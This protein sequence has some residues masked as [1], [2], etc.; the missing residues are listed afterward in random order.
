[1]RLFSFKTTILL[2]IF[3]L[4]PHVVHASKIFTV[5]AGAFSSKTNAQNLITVL[6]SHGIR[7]TAYE[8][9]GLSKVQ[10]GE[11]STQ[12]KADILRK[13]LS[14][15]GFDVFV[16]PKVMRNPQGTRKA[17]IEAEQSTEA[18]VSRQPETDQ[19]L[20]PVTSMP[21][22]VPPVEDKSEPKAQEQKEEVISAPQAPVLLNR[23]VAVVNK[24]VITWSELYRAMEFEAGTQIENLSAEERKKLLK[25]SEASFLESLIDARL[26]LQE[27][28]KLGIE[29]TPREVT[30][31]VETVK[32]KYSMTQAD[33]METLKKEGLTF[34]GYKKRLSEEIMINKVVA[35]EIR[36]KIVVSDDE[37]TKYIE[38][39]RVNFNGNV[40]Y[41]LRQLFLRKPVDGDKKTV[42]EKATLIIKRLRDGEDFSALARIYSDDPSRKIGGDLGSVSRDLLAKEFVE[43]LS[44]MKVGDYSMPFWTEKG[45]HIVKLEDIVSAANADKVKDD[46]RKKLAEERFKKRYKSWMKG[47]REKAYV[48]ARL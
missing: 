46:I 24:E 3:F 21:K 1:M 48:E 37:V 16:L 7:C 26:Q 36:N 38:D 41:R 43:V 10:C 25:R 9:K 4:C 44:S 39:H 32:K 8:Q 27:A 35:R 2:C 31:A 15:L 34:D 12:S 30:E 22:V 28:Q 19:L 33:F 47:L 5:Q 40:N 20:P 29:T 13:K 11:F 42:E 23:V 45:L 14:S 17:D 6:E 18:S